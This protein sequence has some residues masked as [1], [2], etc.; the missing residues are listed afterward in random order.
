[1]TN[2][3]VCSAA[4]FVSVLGNSEDFGSKELQSPTFG[5]KVSL[6]VRDL[7]SLQALKNLTGAYLPLLVADV[8]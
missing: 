1:M 5:I 6:G 4:E 3:R 7:H 8:P 2:K